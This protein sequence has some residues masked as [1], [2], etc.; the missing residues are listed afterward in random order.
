MKQKEEKEEIESMNT[1]DLME[2]FM[3]K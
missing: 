1:E 3:D 2:E